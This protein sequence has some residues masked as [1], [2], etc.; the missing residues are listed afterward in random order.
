MFWGATEAERGSSSSS[1][2][3]MGHESISNQAYISSAVNE[4]GCSVTEEW[5]LLTL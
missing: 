5:G 2:G 3:G 4:T 1:V